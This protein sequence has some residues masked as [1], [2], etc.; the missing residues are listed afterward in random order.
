MVVC[1]P[2]LQYREELDKVVPCLGYYMSCMAIEPLLS[3]LRNKL[4]G[5]TLPQRNIAFYLSAYINDDIVFINDRNMLIIL[6]IF[7]QQL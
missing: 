4:K 1:V 3:M 6:K 2:P 5:L 7:F